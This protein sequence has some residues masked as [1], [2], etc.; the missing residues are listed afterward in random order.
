MKVSPGLKRETSRSSLHDEF[1]NEQKL[2]INTVSKEVSDSVSDKE[3]KRQEVISEIMYTE[4]DF[5]KDL[6]YLRDFWIKP[7]RSPEASPI[8][9]AHVEEGATCLVACSHIRQKHRCE[10]SQH[11]GWVL[12]RASGSCILQKRGQ[13]AYDDVGNKEGEEGFIREGGNDRRRV[14]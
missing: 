7:L 4:R 3:K 2:W 8:P 10:I 6:E 12:G 14:R 11:R 1:E 9:E 5:V 13:A